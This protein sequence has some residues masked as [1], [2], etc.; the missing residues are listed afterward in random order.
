MKTA[1]RLLNVGFLGTGYI[2]DWHAKALRSVPNASLMAVCDR[3]LGRARTFAARHGIA[4]VHPSLEAMLG[5]GQLDV[6]HVLLPPNLHAPFAS[7][8][9]DAGIHV[10]LEKPTATCV[11]ACNNLIEH[12]RPKGVRIGV[13]HNFLFA[14]IYEQL[15]NELRS[16]KL[17]RPDQ[18]TITWCKGLAQLQAGPFDLWMLCEPQN[19]MLEVG[20]HSMA[21][22]L[23]L[24]GPSEIISVHATNPLDLP[25]GVRFFRRWRVEAG[26]GP[27]GVTLNF[28]FAPGFPEHSIHIRGS[29]AS[30]TVDFER[31]TYLL[32]RHTKFAHDFDRY[33][34]SAAEATALRGQART[35]LRRL[36]LSKL[37]HSAGDPYGQSIARTLQAFYTGL[38]N[39]PDPRLSLELGC[40]V[41]R[42]CSE[43]G[44]KVKATPLRA[45]VRPVALERTKREARPEILLLGATGFIGQELTRQL[46][47]QGHP[48]RALVRN[49]S[50]LPAD[51]R[52]Q[53]TDVIVGD[54]SR[55][56]DVAMALAGIRYVYHLARPLVKTWEEFTEH[57]V[58]ATRRVAQACLAAN[59]RRL[60]YTGTIDSYYTGAL[61]TTI[62]EETP[63]DPHIRWRNYYA[64]SKALSEQMLMSLHSQ[65]GL[66]VVIFRPGIV[67][68]RAGNPY[69]WGIGMW[70]WNAVCQ[71]WGQG[72]TPLPLVL[73]EDVARA[74]VTA[75]DAEGIEGESF[76]LVADTQLSA[77]D[78]LQALE[79][80]TGFTLQKI[81]TPPWKLY[82]LDLAKWVVKRAIRHPDHR[83]PS[84]RDWAT[85]TQRSHYDCSKARIRLNWNPTDA[86]A[87]I[88]EKGIQ[89]PA[90]ELLV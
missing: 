33:C 2:A 36:I 58:E 60:I 6:V 66:P 71:V 73:V 28:S 34:M 38:T 3:D 43:I 52:A 14:P 32:R 85:R 35:T 70:S 54:L 13:S 77:M 5:G 88:I 46:I 25:S 84:Y 89:L 69:H 44:E 87:E 22:V 80:C 39:S 48:V 79:K 75:L 11:Q 53:L 74:L 10:L 9:I 62:T 49:P 26:R 24:V 42:T 76:N 50:R 18:I 81:P 29:V 37:S 45:A 1:N 64:Q 19:I 21:H 56:A 31:N 67:I 82:L 17:G 40:D 72:R 12:A 15:R 20:S 57:E 23:D 4:R 51:I 68:G 59:V 8:I 63:L 86:R 83:L 7:E 78:Y 90:S 61:G 65:K 47:A 30:A 27:T 55:E 16:G 41:V